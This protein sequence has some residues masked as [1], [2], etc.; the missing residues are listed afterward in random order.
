MVNLP[1]L[2]IPNKEKLSLLW[3]MEIYMS[4][5]KEFTYMQNIPILW[6]FEKL[7]KNLRVYLIL[8]PG[9]KYL[10]KLLLNKW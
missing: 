5:I 6:K 7:A 4:E 9:D 3:T 10:V 2:L 1:L 8:L